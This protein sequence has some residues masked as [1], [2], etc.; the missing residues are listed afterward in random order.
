MGRASVSLGG[1]GL[2]A[3]GATLAWSGVNDP[4]GG[5]IQVLRDILTGNMPKPGLQV[6]TKPTEPSAAPVDRGGPGDTA[7]RP[8][9]VP[10]GVR[11]KVVAVAK[12]YIGVPYVWAGASMRG[13]DCSGLV[14]VAYRDGAGIN[15]PHLA[16]AQM[17]R[18]RRIPREQV[19]PGDLVGWGVPGNYPHI[20]LAT[21]PD[22]VL[23][24]PT[25]GQKVQYQKLWEKKVSGF[26][27]PDIVRILDT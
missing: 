6:V 11:G 21:G 9:P 5:P 27:Y 7:A 17:A 12:Q 4:E 8:G 24:A 16:T 1:L 23:A 10:Q 15:L 18:G 20:A 22:Q 25:F 26:G 3:A 14:L 2:V 19:Q 13:V